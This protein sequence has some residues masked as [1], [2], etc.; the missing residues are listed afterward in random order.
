MTGTGKVLI[1]DDEDDLRSILN[2][3]LSGEGFSVSEASNGALGLESYRNDPP[4]AVLLDLN[5]PEMNGTRHIDRDQTDKPQGPDH[6]SDS[7]RRH[8]NCC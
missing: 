5:M 6:Y 3:V 1:I 2:D 8:P 4:H 7:T